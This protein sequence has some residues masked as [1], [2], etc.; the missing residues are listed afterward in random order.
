MALFN[1]LLMLYI[2]F[3][4]VLLMNLLVAILSYTYSTR[5]AHHSG[6]AWTSPIFLQLLFWSS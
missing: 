5:V 1:G 2:F 3:A 6:L 4:T